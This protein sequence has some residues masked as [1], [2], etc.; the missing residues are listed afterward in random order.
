MFSIKHWHNTAL[1]TKEER[2]FCHIGKHYNDILSKYFSGSSSGNC[3]VALETKGCF[4]RFL[5]S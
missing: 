4:T 2:S 3:M 5:D 1:R